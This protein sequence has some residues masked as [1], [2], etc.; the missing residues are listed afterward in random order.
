MREVYSVVPHHIHSPRPR[1][2]NTEAVPQAVSSVEHPLTLSVHQLALLRPR[3]FSSD[4]RAQP[5]PFTTWRPEKC[6]KSP[7]L[8]RTLCKVGT[9]T[10]MEGSAKSRKPRGGG[11]VGVIWRKNLDRVKWLGHIRNIDSF[12]F[13]EKVFVTNKMW[14]FNK[15]PLNAELLNSCSY[16]F[17]HRSRHT[18]H[19]RHSSMSQLTTL[20]PKIIVYTNVWCK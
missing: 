14:L 8:S 11:N 3:T 1:A 17:A 13:V 5:G 16:Y 15:S 6:K 10:E 9:T 19:T 18:S 4:D 7:V 2:P 12:C 20:L